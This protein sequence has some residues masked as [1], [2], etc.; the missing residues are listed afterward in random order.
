[1]AEP[2]PLLRDA[3]RGGAEPRD[4]AIQ[5]GAFNSAAQANQAAGNAQSRSNLLSHARAEIDG[6]KQG[7]AKL[8]RA[9]LTGLSRGAALQAC[10]KISRSRG[11]CMVV[12]PDARS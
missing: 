3:G 9:R 8:F 1:M 11:D 5:V 7:R 12:S 4:W 6:V 2:A 10:E